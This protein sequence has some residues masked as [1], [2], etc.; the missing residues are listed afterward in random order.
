MKRQLLTSAFAGAFLAMAAIPN[1]AM[2]Q[3]AKYAANI[4][5]VSIAPAT[6][7]NC[8]DPDSWSTVLQT[9]IKTA[10]KSDLQILGSAQIGL[11]TQTEVQSKGG[12]KD[13]S[14]AEATVKVRMLVDGVVGVANPPAVTF[15]SRTQTLSANLAGLNCTADLITGVVTCEDPEII[16][17]MLDTTS[18]HTFAFVAPNLSSGSHKVELQVAACTA[19]SKQSGMASAS[20]SMGPGT[21]TVEEVRATNLPEGIVIQ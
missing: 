8:S 5:N 3:S 11:M 4:N 18:A 2:A 19:T 20:V 14:S 17:L 13:T 16:D 10:N 9:S 12:A 21:L 1:L 15:N 6:I 7:T